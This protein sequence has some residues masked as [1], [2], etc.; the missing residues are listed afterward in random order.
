MIAI[1]QYVA[2][3]SAGLL[4]TSQTMRILKTVNEQESVTRTSGQLE[5]AVVD[6]WVT[7]EPRL[8][9]SQQ[10]NA[11][12]QHIMSSDSNSNTVYIDAMHNS[13][14]NGREEYA[15]GSE[16]LNRMLEDIMTPAGW[17]CTNV[18]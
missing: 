17:L 4:I 11:A 5:T 2:S 9:G 10:L 15:L 6:Q 8:L 16:S 13:S 18:L 3:F 12:L 7:E 1:A 14:S